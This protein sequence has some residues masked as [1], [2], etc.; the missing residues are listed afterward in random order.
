MFWLVFLE[1][2]RVLKPDGLFYLNAP[3]AGS[4]HRYPVDC[5]RFYPDSGKALV[6]WAR[7]SGTQAT[8]LE[9]FIQKGGNWHDYVC[10]FLKN[11]T[12]SEK[13]SNRI[14]KI[15]KDFENGQILGHEG[16]LNLAETSQNEINIQGLQE[17]LASN[18]PI[19]DHQN[20]Q[21]QIQA[22]QIALTHANTLKQQLENELACIQKSMSWKI[23][24]PFRRFKAALKNIFK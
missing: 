18:T 8:M 15:K 14:L 24:V 22:I 17:Q 11:E 10:V 4:F 9:S 1:I 13:F 16:I 2:M 20:D 7:K 23:T 12:Y 5:W 6:Q 3:S 21:T 19:E